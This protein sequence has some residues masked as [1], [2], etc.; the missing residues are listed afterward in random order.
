[1]DI[2][3]NYVKDSIDELSFYVW[4]RRGSIEGRCRARYS[5]K[6]HLWIDSV[7]GVQYSHKCYAIDLALVRSERPKEMSIRVSVELTGITGRR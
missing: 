5:F 6:E 4:A 1:M 7:Y 2:S 3:H